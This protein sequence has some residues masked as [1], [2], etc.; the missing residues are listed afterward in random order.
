[1]VKNKA[2]YNK[3]SPIGRPVHPSG[4]SSTNKKVIDNN[5]VTVFIFP[6]QAAANTVPPSS[7]SNK[8]SPVT[9][10][11]REIM[12]TT[13]HAGA[14]PNSTRTINAADTNNLSANGSAN[15]P[16]LVTRLSRRAIYPSNQSVKLAPTKISAANNNSSSICEPN[17][18]TV[19]HS[20]GTTVS[21]TKKGINN[22]LK[23]VNL[24]GKFNVYS[25]Y[26]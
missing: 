2:M 1:M 19:P 5:W 18:S 22:N 26:N 10:N 25:P 12:M 20:S 15:F 16:K 17:N 11:S 14:N 8:R 13:T 4:K 24:F 6:G 7:T 21:M 9:A 3:I 23:K